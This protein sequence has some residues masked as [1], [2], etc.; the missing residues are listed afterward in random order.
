M[1][2]ALM[3]VPGNGPWTALIPVDAVRRFAAG[4]SLSSLALRPVLPSLPA[5]GAIT[6]RIPANARFVAN[7]I[8]HEWRHAEDIRRACDRAFGDWNYAVEELA[9]RWFDSEN[10][11]DAELTR[12]SHVADF[13]GSRMVRLAKAISLP[14]GNGALYL[15][16]VG[17]HNQAQIDSPRW[18]PAERTLEFTLVETR[19]VVARYGRHRITQ[20]A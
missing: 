9:G 18:L 19:R 3:E 13:T 5:A 4:D 12:I 1:A 7:T 17:D 10:A 14:V 16:E 20:L 15:H 11:L 6:I 2:S 8:K